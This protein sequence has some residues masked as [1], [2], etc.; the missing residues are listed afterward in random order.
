MQTSQKRPTTRR[1][2]TL[3]E[4]MI[5]IAIIGVLVTI[6]A[7]A[8][9][10]ILSKGPE[11]VT[12]NEINQLSIALESFKAQF[13]FYPPSLF[14]LCE[15]QNDYGNTPLMQDSQYYLLK[16]FPR[17]SSNPNWTVN[18]PSNF[19]DWNQDGQRTGFKILTG[20]QCLV[21]FLGGIQSTT[22]VNGKPVHA[23]NGFS[24]NPA[25]P[26]PAAGATTY[27]P[28]F[29]FKSDRLVQCPRTG[30]LD[31]TDL[32]QRPDGSNGLYSYLDGYKQIVPAP[33]V[34]PKVTAPNFYAVYAYF[35]SGRKRNGYNAYPTSD[36]P[37][38]PAYNGQSV[39]KPVAGV[40]PYEQALGNYHN[41]NT[42]QIISPGKDG[43]FGVGSPVPGA[44]ALNPYGF[45]WTPD[46]AAKVVP[47]CPATAGLG[48]GRD[49][50]TNFNATLLGKQ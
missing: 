8:L 11:M 25:S 6:L 22:I 31:S 18:S 27:G 41:P 40:F 4:L 42:Y 44:A 1:G 9:G 39:A 23:C 45:Y 17:L 21:F 47:A 2:F 34:D 5:V 12:R 26:L 30:P 24:T 13:G 43:I 38:L 50:I 49:D 33:P 3:V 16:M 48:D 10:P 28:Y 20:D 32:A 14:V 46:T 29:E 37:F 15:N 35:S 7:V 36:C 19:I